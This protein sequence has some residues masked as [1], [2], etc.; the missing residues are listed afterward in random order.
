MRPFRAGNLLKVAG[1]G[2]VES[3]VASRA[4]A[5]FVAGGPTAILSRTDGGGVAGPRCGA[6][7]AERPSEP[8]P[9]AAAWWDQ[10]RAPGLPD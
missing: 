2:L 10:R 6:G 5:P 4:A 7:C 8:R 9:P 3:S 1:E